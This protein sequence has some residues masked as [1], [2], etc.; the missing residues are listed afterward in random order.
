M[1][2]ITLIKDYRTMTMEEELTSIDK[3]TV[4]V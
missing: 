2:G 1:T 3:D 4:E